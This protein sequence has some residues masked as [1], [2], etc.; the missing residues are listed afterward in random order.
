MTT[1]PPPN[2][3]F[4]RA[5]NQGG[6]QKP[7]AIVMHGTVTS[8]N[9][10]TA[11]NVANWW[12]GPTSPMSSAHYVVDPAEVIQ[13]VGDHNIA[14]HVGYN[15]GSIGIELC[16]EQQGPANRWLDQDSQ[17]ILDRA[18]RLTAELCLAYGIR[19]F[20]PSIAELKAKGPHGI[21]GHNDSR[22]AFGNTS[23]TDPR[24]F[25][26]PDYLRRVRRQIRKIRDAAEPVAETWADKHPMTNLPRLDPD[27][28]RVGVRG[29]HVR[30]LANRLIA[31]GYERFYKNGPDLTFTRTEDKRA[32]RRFQ[33]DQGWTGRGRNGGANGLPGR[34]TLRRLRAEPRRRG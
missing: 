30:W 10:G 1:Y 20:R 9:K 25:D 27:S 22:L 29:T 19:P 13:C 21:Y 15:T 6:S 31:H 8:D 26:W 11:R 16:D 2:P 17:A 24:D 3:T 7:K 32:V 34:E 4:I 28:Y 12:N 33:L 18:A 23:H 14:Y 5:R